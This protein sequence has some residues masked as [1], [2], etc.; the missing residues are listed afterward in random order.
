MRL[1]A[2]LLQDLLDAHRLLLDDVFDA[3]RDNE[4][5][6][7]LHCVGTYSRVITLGEPEL[8]RLTGG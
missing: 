7:Y 6:V 8:A 4:E 3:S 1:S 2:A 5:W